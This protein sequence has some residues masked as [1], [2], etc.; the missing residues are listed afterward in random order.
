M[1]VVEDE[2]V[3]EGAGAAARA[4]AAATRRV[5]NE[6]FVTCPCFFCFSPYRPVPYKCERNGIYLFSDARI[7]HQ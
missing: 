7:A 3:V 2:V 1:V 6:R 5:A 4:A